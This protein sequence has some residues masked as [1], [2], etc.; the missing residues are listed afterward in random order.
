MTIALLLE[1]TVDAAEAQ[2]AQGL[3]GLPRPVSRRPNR[4][5]GETAQRTIGLT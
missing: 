5:N 4:A 1:Q 2:T 3:T